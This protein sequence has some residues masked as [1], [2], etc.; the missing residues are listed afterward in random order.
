LAEHPIYQVDAFTSDIFG[1]NPA[2]VVPL[3]AWLPDEVMQSIAIENNLS[4]TAFFIPDG[5]NFYLRWFTPTYEIDLCGHATLATAFVILTQLYPERE[6][7]TFKTNVA[8]DLIV[9]KEGDKLTMDFP[10]RAGEKIDIK[11]IPSIVLESMDSPTPIEA[12]KARDLMLVY[13]DEEFVRTTQP[14]FSKLIQYPDAVIITSKTADNKYDFISRF[15]C[16]YD[17][18]IPEDPV[19][20][21]AHCTLAPYWSKQ[22]GKIEMSARQVSERSGDLKLKI[23]NDRLFITGQAKLY[24]K[25]KIFI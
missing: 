20:G 21:S 24:L 7:V 8:G 22:L 11:D 15:F 9:S 19:T 18:G 23:E 14:D 1:G 6:S 12:Y 5:D 10:V 13:E 3:D 2:A 16:P 4:E 17:M 25:G